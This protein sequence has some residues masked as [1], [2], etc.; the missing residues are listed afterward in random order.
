MDNTIISEATFYPIRPTDKGL[1]GFASCLFDGK[2]SLNSIAV[3]TTPAGDIRLLFPNKLLPN[4]KLI[5]VF[6]PV[7]KETYA[8]I[9]EAVIRKIEEMTEKAKGEITDGQEPRGA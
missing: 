6:Y 8:S 4:S 9:K 2:L 7:N 1:I 5:D 3:Y